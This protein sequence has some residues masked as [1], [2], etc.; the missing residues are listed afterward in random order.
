MCVKS[1]RSAIDLKDVANLRFE[2]GVESSAADKEQVLVMSR[3]LNSCSCKK[4]GFPMSLQNKI[5]TRQCRRPE[6]VATAGI[7]EIQLEGRL[8]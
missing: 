3:L 2:L 5:R 4:A 6:S 8:L 1:Y 7:K